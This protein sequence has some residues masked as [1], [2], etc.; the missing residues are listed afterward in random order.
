MYIGEPNTSN[1]FDP[2][3]LIFCY[4]EYI[5]KLSTKVQRQMKKLWKKYCIIHDDKIRKMKKKF[6]S[7]NNYQFFSK[8][9]SSILIA[10]FVTRATT[11]KHTN[12]LKLWYLHFH[13][14]L[15][16]LLSLFIFGCSL[17]NLWYV[18]LMVYK[19]GYMVYIKAKISIKFELVF[20]TSLKWCW[21]VYREPRKTWSNVLSVFVYVFLL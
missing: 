12:S 19:H 9:N 8:F 11:T 17:S 16:I 20:T 5:N 7:S 13:L 18:W 15:H 14:S 1:F 10:S 2:L 4:R 6:K 21:L 3:L